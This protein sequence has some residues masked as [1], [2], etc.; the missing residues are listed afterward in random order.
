MHIEN[1]DGKRTVVLQLVEHQ[2]HH[3]IADF[4]LIKLVVPKDIEHLVSAEVPNSEAF[5]LGVLRHD[6]AVQIIHFDEI[7]ILQSEVLKKSF[8]FDVSILQVFKSNRA[9]MHIANRK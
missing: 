4:E 2:E 8:A 3:S 5:V 1:R 9:A 6:F 7:R